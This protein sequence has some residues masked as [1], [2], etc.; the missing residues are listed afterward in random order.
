[1]R[2]A[3]AE[4]SAAT[5]CR[6]L[7][8]RR[9]V[10]AAPAGRCACRPPP[11]HRVPPRH[12]TDKG[13]RPAA[14]R[15][16]MASR[17][18]LSGSRLLPTRVSKKPL[19]RPDRSPSGGMAEDQPLRLGGAVREAVQPQPGRCPAA[20]RR[21]HVGIDGAGQP[22]FAIAFAP[23]HALQRLQ[24]GDLGVLVHPVHQRL[25]LGPP[26]HQPAHLGQLRGHLRV[27]GMRLQK[28]RQAARGRTGTARRG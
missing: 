16:A 14:G 11:R 17:E 25:Q 1:M 2:A 26:G 13:F 18:K 15:M 3:T 22:A 10:R 19:N 9:M 24:R 28:R 7:G 27:G 12:R 6:S 4:K 23:D 21:R 5:L 8:L 20:Q